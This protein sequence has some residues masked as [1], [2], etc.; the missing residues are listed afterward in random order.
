LITGDGRVPPGGLSTRAGRHRPGT[1]PAVTRV[2]P[3]SV[4]R[5]TTNASA[6][7]RATRTGASGAHRGWTRYRAWQPAAAASAPCRA[8]DHGPGDGRG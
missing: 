6:V 8:S 4:G 7:L 1:G 5:A 2:G 3:V